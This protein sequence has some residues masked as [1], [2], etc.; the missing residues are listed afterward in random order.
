M[1][2]LRLLTC[3]SRRGGVSGGRDSYYWLRSPV[4]DHL[5]DGDQSSI[6]VYD[7]ASKVSDNKSFKFPSVK[8]KKNLHWYVPCLRTQSIS[9]IFQEVSFKHVKTVN[10]L[11]E[12]VTEDEYKH[13]P[14]DTERAF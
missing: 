10:S 4:L 14:G 5:Y 3:V 6:N 11:L 9:I 13:E 8:K 1:H 2:I 7:E 12:F